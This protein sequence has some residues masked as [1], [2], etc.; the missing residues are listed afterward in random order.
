MS[1]L[2]TIRHKLIVSCQ[3]TD[4]EPLRDSYIMSKMALAAAWG[5]AS[6]IRAN[7]VEDI[8]A[9]KREIDLPIIGIFKNKYSHFEV[10][11]TPTM[12]EVRAIMTSN[13]DVIA[14]DATKRPRPDGASLQD[15][16]VNIKKEFPQVLIMADISST[17]EAI[18]AEQFGADVIGTTL[19]GYTEYTSGMDPISAIKDIYSKVSLPIIGE[20]NLDT[21]EKA[22]AAL[23][24]GAFAVVVGGAI[25]RPMDITK[26]FVSE[27]SKFH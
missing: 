2:E 11:I 9:I 10:F 8:V 18:L 13:P 24:A 15:F 12:K 25:T 21:P 22:L 19:V 17:E 3:A 27:M 14:I 5:G 23:N 20:G 7:G 16:I 6:A 1:F 26:K 4:T